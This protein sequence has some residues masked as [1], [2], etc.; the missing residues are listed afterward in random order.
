MS[1][2]TVCRTIQSHRARRRYLSRKK[3]PRWSRGSRRCC[4]DSRRP[5]SLDS[6]GDHRDH[7]SGDHGPR[8]RAADDLG[9]S[10]PLPRAAL[11]LAQVA[12]RASRC[13]PRGVE[14]PRVD[15]DAAR[16]DRAGLVGFGAASGIGGSDPR[17][18]RRR[19]G[20]LCFR[21]HLR[22]RRRRSRQILGTRVYETITSFGRRGPHARPTSPRRHPGGRGAAV[23]GVLRAVGAALAL[24]RRLFAA[25]A[26]LLAGWART[27]SGL[28]ST[29]LAPG[30]RG[31]L[32]SA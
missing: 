23:R 31:S 4:F 24:E 32:V 29:K 1:L 11:V 12:S 8:F 13:T 19:V 7:G 28:S 6:A 5:G 15:P 26:D 3:K 9:S 27:S 16:L 25:N 2:A 20:D 21:V 22:P 17:R 18:Y 14:R 10:L 30:R